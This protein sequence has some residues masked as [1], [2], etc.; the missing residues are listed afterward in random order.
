[1][2]CPYAG[3]VLDIIMLTLWHCRRSERM[4]RRFNVAESRCL[5]RG[6]VGLPLCCGGSVLSLA[7]GFS[8][9][10]CQRRRS[11][12]V[13]HAQFSIHERQLRMANRQITQIGTGLWQDL[14]EPV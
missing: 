11:R 6:S 3:C 12:P 14:V 5:T 9:D 1:M 10:A 8:P 7:L 4:L 13:R 2:P